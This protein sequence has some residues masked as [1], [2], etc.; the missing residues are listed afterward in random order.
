MAGELA[1]LTMI[2][3]YDRRDLEKQAPE[4]VSDAEEDE[5]HD[6]NDGGHQPHHR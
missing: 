3:A 1:C 2:R 4:E 5:D 6:R